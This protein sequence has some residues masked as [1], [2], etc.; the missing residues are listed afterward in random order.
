MRLPPHVT[1]RGG[2]LCIEGVAL[3]DVGQ[4][5]GTPA[6]VYSRAALLDAW[7]TYREPASRRRGAGAVTICYAVKACSNLAIL[8]VF[9][10]AG[11]G[12][13]IVSGGELERVLAAGG[14]PSRIVFSGV[15]KTRDEMRRALE[16]GILCFNV[17]SLAELA[18][19]DA[20]AR[21]MERRARVS[22]RI[23]P[24][25][26][27]RTHPYIA[28]GLKESKFGIAFADAEA[29][30]RTA[31]SMPSLEV[32]GVDCHI[33]SQ[34]TDD[35]PLLEALDRLVELVDR[36]EAAG[37]PIAHVDLG[38]GV[39]IRYRDDDRRI[40]VASYVARALD[41]IDRWRAERHGGRSIDVLFEPGRS[42][43][44]EAGLLLT[45]VLVLKP[46]VVKNF[47]IVDAAMN[48][49]VRPALYDAWHDV[50]P[51][52][53]P[54]IEGGM[55]WDLV[56]PVCESGDWLARDRALD[57][58]QGDLLAFASAGAYA[59][60]MASNYNTRPRAVELLVDGDQAHVVRERETVAS[61]FANE[62]I[63][64]AQEKA[65]S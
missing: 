2:R 3:D 15:G 41:R 44:G 54:R 64:A 46:G 36:L 60:A 28:T 63:P 4:R 7:R 62:R 58:A 32:V 19:L 38:G 29:A 17:E 27:A 18:Q 40:D 22:L 47:A 34:L 9:A 5:F 53:E 35:A 45:R 39:G 59:M 24:D 21:S 1:R 31:A 33:G 52:G 30:F 61:L 8:D 51:V 55:T 10:R 48:D 57:L 37:I 26:D 56:G 65:R 50:L 43:V 11:A 49:L 25:V 42:L 14:D 13:D 23:N 12:F 16:V 20:V 6:Y